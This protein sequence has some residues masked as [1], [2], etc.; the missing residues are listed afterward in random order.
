MTPTSLL[1][2]EVVIEDFGMNI[3]LRGNKRDKS[4]RWS[5]AGVQGT[6]GMTQ[7][8]KHERVTK[9]VVITAATPAHHDI[10]IRQCVMAYQF[11][12]IGK[13]IEQCADL[14]FAQLRPSC[15]LCLLG[16]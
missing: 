15:H 2:S 16:L 6:A 3:D 13:R 14:G 12:L 10:R 11:T 1:R 7:I 5:L 8:A 9:A 4:S